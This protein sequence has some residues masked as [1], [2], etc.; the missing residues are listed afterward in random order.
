MRII[1]VATDGN[2]TSGNGSY[3]TPYKTI[4]RAQL[5]FTSGDQIRL[6]DG[7]Y[8]PTD[9]LIFNNVEGSIFADTPLGVTI[10]PEATL[11]MNAVLGIF[12]SDRFSVH[13][14]VIKQAVRTDT[15][16]VG[17]QALGVN[18]LIVHTCAV[19][20]FETT[21]GGVSTIGIEVSG[22]GRLENCDI[23][24]LSC[25]G[26]DLYGIS[27]TGDVHIVDCQVYELTGG[28]LCKVHPCLVCKP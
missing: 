13:G 24:N 27:V 20:D 4:E 23:Y 12:N 5:S 15:N 18:N 9:S 7:E 21:S 16:Q 2:D 22:S 6:K 19:S 14:V 3:S 1:W 10:Q 17:I 28:G 26:T 11:S 8:N 25:L